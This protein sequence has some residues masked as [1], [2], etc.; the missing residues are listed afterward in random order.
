MK[1]IY[2]F[3]D[4]VE[5]VYMVTQSLSIEISLFKRRLFKKDALRNKGK[6]HEFLQDT[7]RS[8]SLCTRK[9]FRKSIPRQDNRIL[10]NTG[11]GII[12]N[13]L[14]YVHIYKM[15]ETKY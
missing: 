15:N 14:C 10:G 12:I 8:I 13:T 2:L 5:A 1:T 11:P 3:T 9:A 6:K 4:F 7:Y